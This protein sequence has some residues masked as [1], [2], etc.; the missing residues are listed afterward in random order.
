M[1]SFGRFWRT[2]VKQFGVYEK[3][4]PVETTPSRIV[5][6]HIERPSYI[7]GKE[8]LQVPTE[9]EIKDAN[10]ISGMR[11]SCKLAASILKELH[12]FIQPGISTD[13]IDKFA[14][15]LCIEAGAYP[16]PLQYLGFPKSVCTSVNNVIV[17]GIPDLR[18]LKNGDIVNVDVTVFFKGFH[19]DCSKT[20]LVGDVD[21]KGL[22]LVSVTEEC[23]DI[24]TKTC[25]P[26]VP[27]AEI[28]S[29]IFKH[30]KRYGLTVIPSVLGHGIG[31]YFHGPPEVYHT[32]TDSDGKMQAGMTFTIEPALTHGS[33]Y[34]VMLEDDWT[35]VTEDGARCAQAEHTVLV[36]ENGC[37]ILT[38]F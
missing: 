9:P 32:L 13:E 38:R 36:T 37:D 8:T 7:I 10:Q 22:E 14:H 34:S 17:H 29:A 30:A 6:L 12:K 3:V 1:E 2:N 15:N 31:E 20:F 19:G 24:G 28:G 4:L 18:L 26:G 21:D 27:F 35:L 16:S 25:G 23:L 5:P 11:R 33:E